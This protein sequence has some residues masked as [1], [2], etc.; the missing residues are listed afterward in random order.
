MT[1]LELAP[2]LRLVPITVLIISDVVWVHRLECARDG[3]ECL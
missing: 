1:P 2:R 3:P